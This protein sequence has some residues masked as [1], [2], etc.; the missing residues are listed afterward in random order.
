MEPRP[1]RKAARGTPRCHCLGRSPVSSQRKLGSKGA[2]GHAGCRIRPTSPENSRVTLANKLTILP[3]TL[4][5]SSNRRGSCI[6]KQ[7]GGMI[8][9]HP[10]ILGL[11]YQHNALSK[12]HL[13]VCLSIWLSD[14][15]RK[16]ATNL[17]LDP[18]EGLAKPHSAS[19]LIP[20]FASCSK[21]SP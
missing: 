14:M 13:M 12:E 3:L 21:Q 10:K 16:A 18:H 8:T 4:E 2:A 7:L 19:V 20:M 11:T 5:R 6:L 15:C 1:T 17:I 9:K